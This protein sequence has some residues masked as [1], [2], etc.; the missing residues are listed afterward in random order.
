M[1]SALLRVRMCVRARVQSGNVFQ[2]CAF[3]DLRAAPA[4]EWRKH[5][6]PTPWV[7]MATFCMSV[8]CGVLKF[9]QTQ[10][11]VGLS[12]GLKPPFSAS[13]L[14]AIL[15]LSGNFSS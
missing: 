7:W 3:F 2:H 8:F 15:T 12:V 11:Q 10:G 1:E 5:C 14:V 4:L 6:P 13:E 9:T